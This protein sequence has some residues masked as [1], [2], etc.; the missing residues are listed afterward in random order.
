MRI[1]KKCTLKN[2]DA[3]KQNKK[4]VDHHERFHS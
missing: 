4:V 1:H 3:L 2:V